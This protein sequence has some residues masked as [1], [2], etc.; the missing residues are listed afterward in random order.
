[1]LGDAMGA[2]SG[3][4]LGPLKE[5]W[6][7]GVRWSPL[8]PWERRVRWNIGACG[9]CRNVGAWGG[10][11]GVGAKAVGAEAV[12]VDVRSRGVRR[13]PWERGVRRSRG[14]EESVGA[15]GAWSPLE[16]VIGD[17]VGEGVPGG[18]AMVR[19]CGCGWCRA[20]GVGV[21]AVNAAAV[22]VDEAEELA[23]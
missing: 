10:A 22:G 12:G 18:A 13:S 21:R 3:A 23:V 5:P 11:Y 2:S 6:G 7:R 1:M 15:V 20:N 19:G 14:S 17:T 8:E 16:R 9:W 4:P